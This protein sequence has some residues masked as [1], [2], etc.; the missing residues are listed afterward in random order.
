MVV[1]R[2]K[3]LY[4]QF[5]NTQSGK[6]MHQIIMNYNAKEFTCDH[7]NNNG[8]D[9]RREN[10]RICTNQ[11]NQ[12]NRKVSAKNSSGILG[13]HRHSKIDKWIAQ[14]RINGKA[15]HLGSFDSLEDAAKARLEAEKYRGE[16]NPKHQ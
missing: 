14:I 1:R 5:S 6:Y 12:W 3:N 15:K 11:Q 8:L 4:A 2:H 9:N 10:L 13:V 16:F 7:I